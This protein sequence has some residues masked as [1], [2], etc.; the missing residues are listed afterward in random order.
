[1]GRKVYSDVARC[2]AEAIQTAESNLPGTGDS[3]FV[4][5]TSSICAVLPLS[6]R[7]NVSALSASSLRSSLLSL[8]AR[9]PFV[10]KCPL[11]SSAMCS[12]ATPLTSGRA[13]KR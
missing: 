7:R 5:F 3:P 6:S 12:I 1:M 9:T 2:A 10:Q 4:S 11:K 8:D 13:R